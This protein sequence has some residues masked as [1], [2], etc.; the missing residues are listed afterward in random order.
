MKTLCGLNC[1]LR[2]RR[3]SQVSIFIG[4]Q[5]LL[6]HDN[7]QACPRL[8]IPLLDFPYAPNPFRL[9]S[10]PVI[11][12]DGAYGP[13]CSWNPV[14]YSAAVPQPYASSSRPNGRTRNLC[15]VF[16]TNLCCGDLCLKQYYGLHL[17]RSIIS[18]LPRG[19][20]P[21]FN[22]IASRCRLRRCSSSE[23]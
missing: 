1:L 21:S 23:F 4:C 13:S 5:V 7:K 16:S 10:D 8:V 18:P 2:P 20:V 15:N 6:I 9:K 3:R 14:P 19:L 22:T 11:G 12:G 17:S